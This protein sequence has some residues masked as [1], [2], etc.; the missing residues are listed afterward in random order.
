M[1]EI[2]NLNKARKA[3]AKSDKQQMAQRNRLA[4]GVSRHARS[5]LE[6]ELERARRELDG[7]KLED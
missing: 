1:A 2:I 7:H 5:R 4:K 6:I 3:R